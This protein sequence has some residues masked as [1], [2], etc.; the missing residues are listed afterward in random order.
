M[1]PPNVPPQ[2]GSAWRSQSR[3]FYSPSW[4]KN[5]DRVFIT[6][7]YSQARRGH[8]Q[9]TRTPNMHSLTYA[10]DAVNNHFGLTLNY[11]VAKKRLER[12]RL[13]Y[14]TF[15]RL[16]TDPGFSWLPEDNYILA[17]EP[18]WT[19]IVAVSAFP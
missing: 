12:L 1:D 11:K 14:N 13:R 19:R 15:R 18:H 17:A 16:I 8:K 2:G 10:V 7:M 4:T 3:W 9:V 6:A 5:H